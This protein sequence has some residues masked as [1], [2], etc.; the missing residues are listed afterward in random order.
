M[1]S[2]CLE[3]NWLMIIRPSY[4]SSKFFSPL[5]DSCHTWSFQNI[6]FWEITL[7]S[8][9]KLHYVEWS[10]IKIISNNNPQEKTTIQRNIHNPQDYFTIHYQIIDNPLKY[11][12][13]H[14]DTLHNLQKYIKIHKEKVPINRIL[15]YDDEWS[16]VINKSV[17]TKLI[18][19]RPLMIL[20]I[21]IIIL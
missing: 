1:S 2:F 5:T 10:L 18:C 6:L 16:F 11:L 17:Y 21:N 19:W 13:I 7:V 12:T 3:L 14:W 15:Q 9:V 8:K 20:L 4:G